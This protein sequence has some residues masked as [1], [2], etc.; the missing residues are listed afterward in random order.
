MTPYPLPW[1]DQLTIHLL[2]G[3]NLLLMIGTALA[4]LAS[5]RL[6]KLGHGR[7]WKLAIIGCLC[8]L[9]SIFTG[10]LMHG[11]LFLAAWYNPSG[12]GWFSGYNVITSL[13]HWLRPPG[14]LLV[15]IA[16]LRHALLL[17]TGAQKA[18]SAEA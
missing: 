3:S 8:I 9:L 13:I 5:L 14:F 16:I 18:T 6:L 1:Y 11:V 12:W 15:G 7:H 2:T 4:L 10:Y 17:R